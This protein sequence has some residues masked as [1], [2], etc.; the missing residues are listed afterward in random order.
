MNDAACCLALADAHLRGRADAAQSQMV[1]FLDRWRRRCSHLLILGDFFEYLAGRNRKAEYEYR[2]VLAAIA[3]FAAIDY[4]E[5]NHDFDLSGGV[6]GLERVRLHPAPVSLEL[7]GL[8][9]RLLHGDRAD[10]ADWASR[11]LRAALQS[12]PLR[13]LRDG[14]LPQGPLF[15][16][17]LAFAEASR[18][19]RLASH[20]RETDATRRLALAELRTA[21]A[22]AVLFGHTHCGLLERH[23]DGVLLNPGAARPGGSFLLLHPD[24]AELRRWPGGDPLE[25]LSLR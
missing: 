10:P 11:G 23:R 22:A 18:R 14:W 2:P 13:R 25:R 20:R 1:A 16:F 24:R 9:C 4:V 3:R 17:A 12:Q 5:G 15:R 21:R 8:R 19:H 6:P 7:L